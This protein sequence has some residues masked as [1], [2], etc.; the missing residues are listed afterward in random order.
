MTYNVFRGTLN[1]P[2]S[3]NLHSIIQYIQKQPQLLRFLDFVQQKQDDICSRQTRF[4]GSKYAK[5]VF[6]GGVFAP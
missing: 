4:L 3:I 5:N 1:L 6:A 2:Q